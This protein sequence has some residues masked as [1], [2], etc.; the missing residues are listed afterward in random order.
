MEG[1][2]EMKQI[3]E[4]LNNVPVRKKVKQL[5]AATL[6]VLMMNPVT[7]Y[8]TIVHAQEAGIITAFAELSGEISGQQL[9]VGAKESD[10]HL[11]DTLE[12]TIGVPATDTTESTAEESQ[13]G[14]NTPEEPAADEPTGED[15]AV[16]GNDAEEPQDELSSA[17]PAVEITTGAAIDAETEGTEREPLKTTQTVTLENITWEIDAENS[18]SDTYDSS[19][20]GAYYTYVPVLPEGY[21]VADG[22]SLPE[23]SVRIGGGMMRMMA[24][25]TSASIGAV[26]LQDGKY[27]NQAGEVLDTVPTGGTPYLYYNGGV[28][29]VT[30]AYVI[31]PL[32]LNFTTP[33]ISIQSGTLTIVG[34]GSLTIENNN[35]P[36]VNIQSGAALVL[37]GA[38]NFKAQSTA[39]IPIMLGGSFVTENGYSG[40]I[41][42]EGMGSILSQMEEIDLNTTGAI[43]IQGKGSAPIISCDGSIQMTGASITILN[44]NHSASASNGILVSAGQDVSLT[45]TVGGVN[46]EA[47]SNYP[48]LDVGGNIILSAAENV[49]V[50]N[51]NMWEPG[52]NWKG[53]KFS[54]TAAEGVAVYGQMIGTGEQPSVE[55]KCTGGDNLQLLGGISLGNN[56]TCTVNSN[57]SIE[58]AGYDGTKP[59]FSGK[60]L[61]LDVDNDII[62]RRENDDGS[63]VP[64][65]SATEQQFTS[66]NSVVVVSGSTGSTIRTKDGQTIQAAFGGYVTSECL[67]LSTPPA[68]ATFYIAGKGSILYTPAQ[69]GTPAVLALT[70]AT[71][72]TQDNA[73]ILPD[74]AVTMQ[75]SGKN[76]L[77]SDT[78]DG[79]GI[80]G[81]GSLTITSSNGGTLNME[82]MGL[83]MEF[84]EEYDSTITIG[85]NASVTAVSHKSSAVLTGGNLTVEPTAK[86]AAK[87]IMADVMIEGNF[88][89]P[90]F[91]GSVVVVNEKVDPRTFDMTIHGTCDMPVIMTSL[92]IGISQFGAASLHIPSGA[93]MTIPSGQPLMVTDM[94]K[95]KLEGKIIN[96]GMICLPVG[97]TAGQIKA[98]KL[99]GSGVVLVPESIDGN[100]MPS[101]DGKF[102]T[103]GGVAVKTAD[104]LDLTTDGHSGK[105]VANDGYSWD[106]STLTLGGVFIQGNITLPANNA[107]VNTTAAT[108]I[109]GGITGAG[110]TTMHLTFT[111][112]APLAING[113]ISAG[114]NGDTVTVQ[115]G[116]QVTV[117]GGL[118]LGEGGDGVL[119]VTGSG[120]VMEVSSSTGY[121]VYCQNVKVENGATLTVKAEGTDSVGVQAVKPGG[122]VSV[123]GGSTLTAG[124]DYGVFLIDGKLT[125]DDTSKLIT[126]GA[127]APFCILDTTSSKAQSE[128]LSLANTPSDTEIA[129]MKGTTDFSGS[130][131]TYWSLIPKNGKLGVENEEPEFVTLTGAKTG[132]LTFA[133]ATNPGGNN[134]N[135]DGD[136]DNGSSS[137]GSS[138]TATTTTPE[139]K[140]DQPVIGS[141]NA[142]GKV[143]DSHAVVLITDSIVK[144]AIEKAQ[145]AASAQ[146]KTANGIGAEVSVTAPGAKSFTVITERAALNRLVSTN[147]K[148][149]QII[150][151]PANFCFDQA[152]LK[153]QQEQ[154]TG[155]ITMMLKPA[156]VKNVR[157]ACDITL[158]T[159]KNGKTVNITSMNKGSVTL[160]LPYTLGKNEA[161]GGVYAVYVDAK[162]NAARIAGSAYDRN[163]GSVIFTTNYFSRYGIGYTASAAKFTDISSHWAKESIDYVVGRGLFGSNAAGK[164][165]PDAAVTRGDF[166]TALGRLAGVDT[167]AYMRSSFTDVKAGSYYL[168]YIE[169]AYSKGIIQGIGNNQFAPER[170]VTR[171]EIALIFAN[172]AK[173]TGYTLPVIREA[174]TFSDASSIGSAYKDAV[175]A[176]QQA[177][178]IMGKNNNVFHPASSATRA[179]AAAMLTRYVKLTIHPATAQGWAKNDSGQWM[180]L[181]DGKALTGWQTIGGKVYCFDSSGSAFASGWR[182][183]AKGKWV[184]LSSDGSA[185][186]GWKDIGENGRSKR[187]YFT[188][189]GIRVSGKWL[190]I[191]GKWY[192]F[193]ADGSLATSTKIDGYEVDANGVRK[194]K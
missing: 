68:V 86:F 122:N 7:G 174:T 99:T 41:R 139:K 135:G 77:H 145:S 171:E 144:A 164:F 91:N 106:G 117:N 34:S 40:A 31:N 21:A 142:A 92:P 73:I 62:V 18:A 95:L 131:H 120:T 151:L 61:T 129:S 47:S 39:G 162:G 127:V 63:T 14:G 140:P 10:I 148:L 70:N 101:K 125:V 170:A 2:M 49:S 43:A 42:L 93:Q 146:G 188:G 71:I 6:A 96:N 191:D 141:V 110:G 189:D 149:F 137:S 78:K 24:G 80:V 8:G 126:N 165:N 114:S 56:G 158:S 84:N 12:V 143:T 36:C 25:E 105:T 65:I 83:T 130:K 100:G 134:N 173:A 59:V 156:T 121:A 35:T 167:K 64:V 27:Y 85:G 163:S 15:S 132:M 118:S 161:V 94:A 124:C 116:A 26:S 82:S 168:P 155:D 72:D 136:D 186:T 169:W 153:Q 22:V 190:Q 147:V 55:I 75:L 178:V 111:G 19:E 113:G 16:S 90:N 160:S 60:S 76:I 193:Y 109:Q 20:N 166:V 154:G 184:F 33:Q 150:G 177:G 53:S 187:Y 182:Q 103:N 185:V 69:G 32:N 176:M 87:G 194:T 102:Y 97:A 13:P 57:G 28:L 119:T 48:I 52:V 44:P 46:L 58:I 50:M 115:S 81:N 29:T 4:R 1:I 45:A 9:A 3:A 152:S 128:L 89:A 88:H 123:T 38:V 67:N 108:M 133:K 5:L 181:K 192:Y 51:Y 17:A 30:G 79:I 175:K 98:M 179:E 37:A 23:I 107:T 180:Y 74:G 172:Y 11:P 138:S 183:N 66:K 159:V 104:D 157:S 54:I 112:A